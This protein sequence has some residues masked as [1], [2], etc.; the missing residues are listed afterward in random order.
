M[1]LAKKLHFSSKYVDHNVL[2]CFLFFLGPLLLS[3]LFALLVF[4]ELFSQGRIG[5][6]VMLALLS[7]V[8]FAR[9]LNE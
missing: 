8:F 4:L 6:E 3:T 7:F 9:N 5:K 1:D 2:A